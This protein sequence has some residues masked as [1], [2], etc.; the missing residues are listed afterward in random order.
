[1][2]EAW[3]QRA[4][5]LRG[6]GAAAPAYCE[7]GINAGH[8]TAAMLLARDDLRVYSFDLH[9]WPYSDGVERFLST[10]FAGRWRYKKKSEENWR[11]PQNASNRALS[12][13]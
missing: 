4:R 3:I 1:M 10:A 11:K 8:G 7:I 5:H 13:P 6:I 2:R 9:P 12:F